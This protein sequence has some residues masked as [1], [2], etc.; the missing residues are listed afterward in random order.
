MSAEEEIS[1]DFEISSVDRQSGAYYN[2]KRATMSVADATDPQYFRDFTVDSETNSINNTIYTIDDLVDSVVGMRAK[3]E[4]NYWTSVIVTVYDAKGRYV[5]DYEFAKGT[6][7]QNMTSLLDEPLY[8]GY[9][10]SLQFVID[11]QSYGEEFDDTYSNPDLIDDR[12]Q[13]VVTVVMARN[14]F[15]SDYNHVTFS[16]V[17]NKGDDV[18]S[19][20]K[21]GDYAN[22][23][24]W[25][26]EYTYYYDKKGQTDY[27]L[28]YS[29]ELSDVTKDIEI[30]ADWA[31][32][33]DGLDRFAPKKAETPDNTLDKDGDGI[34]TCD[35]YY[36][37]TGL[38]WNEKTNQCETASGN[39]VVVVPDTSAR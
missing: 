14:P 25:D 31:E 28:V 9:T 39:A 2:A 23:P 21:A 10:V 19:L 11:G 36:G 27:V 24:G 26:D 29:D 8:D 12:D 33:K 20:I 7:W 16:Y 15:S 13:A 38:K 1:V 4:I 22:F 35:E 32:L 17:V 37:V 18:Q 34:V 6:G 5:S 30:K 3:T